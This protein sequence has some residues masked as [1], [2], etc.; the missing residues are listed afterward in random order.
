MEQE[1]EQIEGTVEDIIYENT[2]NGYT[3][4]E[5]SGGG[6]L[7]VVCGVV[8]FLVTEFFTEG[9]VG[10]F[11]DTHYS[12]YRI[13]VEGLPLFA[14]GFVC[15]GVNIVSIGYFQSVERDRPA[16]AVTLSES[17]RLRIRG[18]Q[19][20]RPPADGGAPRPPTPCGEGWRPPR[21]RMT[22]G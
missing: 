17:A 8:V 9:I 3:V 7:T 12:A 16:M 6:V 14:A 1:L 4:F 13:A 5:I 22:T 2:D 15:F 20:R 21:P 11:V 10:M 19:G 18:G